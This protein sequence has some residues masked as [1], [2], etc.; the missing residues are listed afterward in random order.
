VE[1]ERQPTTTQVAMLGA[2]E[3]DVRRGRW[4]PK[5]RM[6][7][8]ASFQELPAIAIQA[9]KE[10]RSFERTW[11]VVIA[12][13]VPARISVRHRGCQAYE[14]GGLTPRLGPRPQSRLVTRGSGGGWYVDEH[15][16][17]PRQH[18]APYAFAHCTRI[19]LLRRRLETAETR[20][21]LRA[22]GRIELE[23]RRHSDFAS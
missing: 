12:Q 10:N 8:L 2:V 19:V 7:R 17:P 20:Q 6:T 21:V 9:I 18:R 23:M 4:I 14:R 1:P 22:A 13:G 3:T 11:R 5:P 16:S 15:G